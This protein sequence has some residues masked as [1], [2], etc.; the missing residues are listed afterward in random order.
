MNA[1]KIVTL[2]V[3][4][5]ML[6]I[7]SAVGSI[8]TPYET[9]RRLAK[10]EHLLQAAP[11]FLIS[12]A[13][14]GWSS[15]V[16]HGV[17]A[18]P[19]LLTVSFSKLVFGFLGGFGMIILSLILIGKL[20][21]GVGDLRKVFLPLSY[22][23][24]PT[25]IWFFATSI[26]SLVFPPPRTI[27]FPGQLFSFIFLSFSLFLFFW[28]SILYYLTLRFSMRLDMGKIFTA[29][30][31]LFPLGALYALVM[32]RMGIFRVPFI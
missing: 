27:S 12:F 25:I 29:S 10:G 23:L 9:Y 18:N 19:Y 1:S 15:L 28:K 11:I 2:I 31:I 3:T 30:L 24:L 16:H 20:V 26:M 14:F 22:S 32:Y 21:G 4:S 13:Y 8:Q 6:F 7:R 5:L 17:T